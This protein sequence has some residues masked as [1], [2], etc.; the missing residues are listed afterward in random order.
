MQ[1]VLRNEDSWA[2]IIG[3]GL[4]LTGLIVFFILPFSGVAQQENLLKEELKAQESSPYKTVAWYR[5]SEERSVLSSAGTPAGSAIKNVLRSPGKWEYNPLQSLYKNEAPDPT[6]LPAAEDSLRILEERALAAQR[7]FERT[8][9]PGRDMETAARSAAIWNEARRALDK[10]K[11]GVSSYNLLWSLPVLAILFGMIFAIGGHFLGYGFRTFFIGFLGIFGLA[12]ISLILGQQ[13]DVRS[14]GFGYPLWGIVLGMVISNTIGTPAWLLPAVRTE[15]YIKTGLVLLGAEILFGKILSIGLPGIFVAWVV[16]PV[17]L[18]LTYWFG[19]KVLKITSKTLNITIS[20]DMSVCGVSAAIATA[21]ASKA[22]KEELTLAVGLSMVFT[23][24]M[25]VL[26]PAFINMT[27]MPEVLGGAWIGGTIDAT[28]AVVAAGAFLGETALQVAATIKMIQNML[29]GLIAFFVAYYFA[30]ISGNKERGNSR[31]EAKELWNRFPKFILGFVGASILISLLYHL[32]GPDLGE[33]M[34]D[35]GLI[36]SFTKD[37][38]SWL[39]CLAF[40]SIGLSVNFKAL[41]SHF[42]GGKPLILYACGQLFNL[43]L[44]LAVAYLM[45]YIVFPEITESL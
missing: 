40:V 4:V 32:A 43:L 27:G 34:I 22:S 37:L 9:T 12:L 23:S 15:F 42:S 21:A 30:R 41:K 5:L 35:R 45:F 10:A 6:V 33:A 13:T 19:Q 18:V 2:I 8:G 1:R 17:V 24:V 16:T 20:A 14:M 26:L 31:I 11:K 3:L 25:M 44:T 38:R 29:I 39:F 36:R 7:H 28:G